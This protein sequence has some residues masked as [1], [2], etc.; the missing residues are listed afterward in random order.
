VR[1][2]LNIAARATDVR[3]RARAAT[4]SALQRTHRRIAT[5]HLACDEDCE[6]IS[7]PLASPMG[8]RM[9]RRQFLAMLVGAAAN[10]GNVIE[11]VA[12]PG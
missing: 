4:A 9:K 3:V 10:G 7:L 8:D 1:Q 12:Q 11:Q 6:L 2:K 5:Q